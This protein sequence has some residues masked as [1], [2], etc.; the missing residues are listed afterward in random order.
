M[1]PYQ[2][3]QLGLTQ[4][5]GSQGDP[6]FGNVA[7]LLHFNEPNGSTTT[8]DSS[9]FAHTVT[10]LGTNPPIIDN[11]GGKFF[12]GARSRAVFLANSYLSIA[13]HSSFDISGTTE[14]C[15]EFYAKYNGSS[16]AAQ[17]V[18]KRWSSVGGAGSTEQYYIESQSGRW[19]AGVH[20]GGGAVTQV[21]TGVGDVMTVGNWYHVALVREGNTL[22][23]YQD[24]V[25][26]D[27]NTLATPNIQAV[28]TPTELFRRLNTGSTSQWAG[29]LDEV[30][31][32]VGHPRY[33]ANFTPPAGQFQDF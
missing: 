16:P 13:N 18:I 31:V 24:G 17:G 25:L 9:S 14:F 3:G 7:L 5:R 1:T 4:P 30:R 23:I 27:S 8:V 26:K 12:G 32:T 21:A 2:L 19:F 11:P 10:S 15:I 22:K 28:S 33:T 20:R 6:L 29:M